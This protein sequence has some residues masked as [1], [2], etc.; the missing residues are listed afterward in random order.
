MKSKSRTRILIGSMAALSLMSFSLSSCFKPNG[1]DI[2]KT[3]KGE[4]DDKVV[5]QTSQNSYYPLMK[6]LSLLVDL[7]N[8]EKANTE[9]FL[10]VELQTTE[11]TNTKSELELTNKV[12]GDITSKS[13]LVP[14]IILA[15]LNAA[16]KINTLDRLLDVNGSSVINEAYFDTDVYNN[17]NKLVGTNKNDNKIYA[18]PFDITETDALVFNKPLMSLLFDFIEKGGGTV[19]KESKIYKEL[20]VE[21][22][23][24][25]IQ[26]KKWKNLE[27]KGNEVFK[28]WTVDD[29]TFDNFES[30]LEFSD[31]IVKNLK[32]KDNAEVNTKDADLKVFLVTYEDDL[33]NK[34]LWS[35]LG[36]NQT[37]WLWT[38]KADGDILDLDFANAKKPET[39]TKIGEAFDFLKN[40]YSALDLNNEQLLRSVQYTGGG[41]VSW[42]VAKFDAAF[43]IAPHIAW[44]SSMFSPYTIDRFRKDRKAPL[45]AEDITTAKNK[46]AAPNEVLWKNQIQKFDKNDKTKNTFWIGGSSLVGIKTSTK[47]DEQAKKFLEWLF[48]INSTIT[49]SDSIFKGET[50]NSILNSQGGYIFTS[51]K[52]I[53]DESKTKLKEILDNEQPVADKVLKDGPT[54]DDVNN[55]R[56]WKDLN[57][58]KAALA[59]LSNFLDFK[60]QRD[61]MPDKNSIISIATD[62][63]SGKILK[64]LKDAIGGISKTKEPTN[65]TKE[66][67]LEEINKVLNEN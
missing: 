8:K 50:V 25:K 3:P 30:I 24:T 11:N 62:D 22:F 47:R 42:N 60:K 57:F 1:G 15:D 32:I 34:F 41:I 6:T 46:Y 66:K 33:F 52:A 5:I 63:K 13:P 39:Q 19:D 17:F 61:A 56:S 36:N 51:K 67:L 12:V 55:N 64:I 21:D 53:S 37:S 48:N 2:S 14:N 9:G 26:N 31:K 16:Y 35:K 10:K 58:N 49:Q 59:T 29:N 65:L 7:Y 43:G 20:K 38:Q 44:N 4:F 27:V 23:T 40:H 45:T 54:V 28:D 18:I